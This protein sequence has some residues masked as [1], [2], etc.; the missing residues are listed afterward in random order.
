MLMLAKADVQKLLRFE[1]LMDSLAEGFRQASAGLGSI[2]DR[3]AADAKN[4]LVAAMPFCQPGFANGAKLMTVN[5]RNQE[6]GLDYHYGLL[7]LFDEEDGRP[8]AVMDATWLTEFRTAAVSALTARL[9]APEDS[10]V[11]AII[12][13]GVQARS[14]L[15]LFP[16]LRDIAEI[17]VFSNTPQRARDVAALD[18]RGR[19]VAT[20]AEAVRGADIVCCCTNAHEPV[21]SRAWIKDGAHLTS[22]GSSPRG[23]EL[24][25]ETLTGGQLI[26]EARE[27]SFKPFPAGALGLQEI[28]PATAIEIGELVAGTRQARRTPSQYTVF[29]SMGHA[30]ED[31]V[32]AHLVYQ[33][34]REQG[35]GREMSLL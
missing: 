13:S 30:V 14:H 5:P 12:G 32:A 23:P 18:P 3:I 6:Q 34:A 11:L 26:V 9:L 7:C 29:R 10:K 21:L 20:V 28:D 8:I 31:A 35:V 16:K 1:P 22:V 19:A 24:D 33:A 25:H 2:P 4:G 27:A 17:R 15:H